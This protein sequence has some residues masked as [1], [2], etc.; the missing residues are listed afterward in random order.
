MIIR[1]F[2]FYAILVSMTSLLGKS[3]FKIMG[4]E[5]LPR[6]FGKAHCGYLEKFIL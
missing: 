4:R 2:F 1:F 6:D 3:L 5:G